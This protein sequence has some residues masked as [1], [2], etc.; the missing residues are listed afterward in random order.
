[1]LFRSG[2][3]TALPRSFPGRRGQGALLRDGTAVA[4]PLSRLGNRGRRQRGGHRP[5]PPRTRP[6]CWSCRTWPTACAPI[7]SGPP[8]V[9]LQRGRG[10]VG[11]LL[12]RDELRTDRAGAS[13]QRQARPLQGPLLG[14]AWA[15]AG[16]ISE[17]DLLNLRTIRCAP[18]GHPTPRLSA[19]DVATGSLGL[20][21]A[22]RVERLTLASTGPEPATGCSACW[23]T[24]RPRRALAG[25]LRPLLPTTVW[26]TSWQS[27]T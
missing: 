24:A 15:E 16:G 20:G 26:I 22:L 11:A 17:P 1:M 21:W 13:G 6:P 10:R 19:V 5:A 2:H 8:H 4:P 25:K 9:V 23:A 12:P 14:A 27:S 3:V 18:E 7:P